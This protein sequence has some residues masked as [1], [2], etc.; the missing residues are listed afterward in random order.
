M[1]T[2]FSVSRESTTSADGTV[3]GYRRLGSGPPVLV[4]HGSMQAAQHM[5]RLAYA[6]ADDF[7]V[8]V[9]D[10]RGRGDSG[11]HGNAYQLAREIED[12]AAVAE[13]TGATRIF[14]LSSGGL[15]TLYAARSLPQLDRV[16][17]YEPPLSVNGS[18]P[19]AWL[20]RFDREIAA[21]EP[22]KAM[23]TALKSLGVD[24][25]FTRLPRPMLDLVMPL[26]VRMQRDV[27]DGDVPIM[28][29]IPTMHY[30][31]SLINETADTVHELAQLDARVLLL[32]GT[33]SPQ[34]LATALDALAA[35]IP[36]A[37]QRMLPGLGHSGPDED[38]KP[39]VV[40]EVLRTFFR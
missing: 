33:R 40:A 34:Y 37:E 24:P 13:A 11:P 6:L 5:M 19:T 32:G 27:P 35:T 25:L 7:T 29:L 30:D 3:I 20:D 15:V 22:A 17:V 9:V 8:D 39:E 38:G 28:T 4:L 12:V 31:I 2:A 21:A 18:A 16:A 10:R 14:G 1:R 23:I 26:A 36:G